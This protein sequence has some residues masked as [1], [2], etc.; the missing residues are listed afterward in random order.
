M[1]TLQWNY[2]LRPSA[3]DCIHLPWLTQRSNNCYYLNSSLLNKTPSSIEPFFHP[4]P[5]GHYVRNFSAEAALAL[6]A[7]IRQTTTSLL[8]STQFA[9]CVCIVMYTP[10]TFIVSLRSGLIFHFRSGSFSWRCIVG[11]SKW[12]HLQR[13]PWCVSF[14]LAEKQHP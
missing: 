1:S 9:G 7:W 8:E 5:H 6:H 13:C 11:P 4:D 14:K 3:A 2:R 10:S 12:H